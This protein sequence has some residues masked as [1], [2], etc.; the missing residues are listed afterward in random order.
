MKLAQSQKITVMAYSSFGPF[1]FR[2]LDWK[3]ANECTLLFEHKAVVEIAKKHNR[4]TA[5]VLLRWSTQQGIIVIPKA[6]DPVLVRQNLN[7]IQF[8]LTKEE[9][10]AI[11]DLDVGMRFNNPA[12][13]CLPYCICL[14]ARLI[15]SCSPPTVL[16]GAQA[17][18]PLRVDV[19][20]PAFVDVKCTSGCITSCNAFSRN[21]DGL[22][23][24]EPVIIH[25]CAIEQ[26]TESRLPEF[27]LKIGGHMCEN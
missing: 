16:R 7:H 8:D 22:Y 25:W 19:L 9:I 21:N 11:D 18:L 23:T 12:D 6:T 15:R 1:S 5:E 4:T 17:S 2:E 3:R 10:Q 27:S 24:P 14:A 20:C 26:V 13:V